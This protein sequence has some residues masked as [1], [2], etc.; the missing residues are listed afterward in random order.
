[1]RRA[2]PDARMARRLQEAFL[3]DLTGRR[4]RSPA[5]R[6]TLF[7][8]P[9][10]GRVADRWHVYAHGYVARIVEALGLEYAAVCRI[11]GG[12]AFA[13]LVE[14]YLGVFPPRSFDLARVGDRLPQL[15]D[16]DRLS[17][18]LPFLPDLARLERKLAEVF[19]AADAV[20]LAWAELRAKSPE[21]IADIPLDAVPAV[22]LLRSA[23]PLRA[24]WSV[25]LKEDDETISV[26]LEGRPSRVLVSRRDGR[27]RV[28]E[29]SEMEAAIV[30]AAGAGGLT[31]E[32]LRELSGVPAEP[33]SL[34]G[35]LDAFR[36]LVER[37]VF[38]HKRSTGW[39]GA[40]EIPKEDRS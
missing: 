27:V 6:E 7:R 8:R 17:A 20:P 21:E 35:F 40:L 13:S 12:E 24:L 15:L 19:T 29:V 4:P 34:S 33:A 28:E 25:R 14:R 22:A 32:E 38:V 26:A 2:R 5:E 9:R 16:F 30:E 11:L 3:G 36:A 18:E 10:R 1:M 39:T 23:W 31:L 37:G